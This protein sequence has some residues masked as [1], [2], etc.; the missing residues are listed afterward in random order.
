MPSKWPAS[1]E[2]VPHA[3]W[4][5]RISQIGGRDSQIADTATMLQC[6]LCPHR[7]RIREGQ[8]GRCGVR[9]N[10]KGSP[11]LPYWAR[12]SSLAL[13]PM[14]KKPLY[15]FRPGTGVL[16]VGF[17]GCNLACPFCQNWTISQSTDAATRL[18]EPVALVQEAER[19]GARS[20]A[21]TYSEPLIHF[22][23]LVQA[24]RLA[25]DKG[26]SNVLVTN[27]CILEGPARELLALTDAANVDL[28]SGKRETYT[29]VLGGDLE[30][31]ERFIALAYEAGVHLEATTLV[32]PN[33]NDSP[34]EIDHCA[35]FLAALSPDL[36]WHLSAYHP[37]FRWQSPPT[38]P[39]V[40]ELMA[41][42]ARKKLRYV[43]VGNVW[44]GTND[45]RCP[46]C[47]HSVIRR[48]GYRIDTSG[49]KKDPKTQ[50]HTCA[51]CGARLPIR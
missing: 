41:T 50:N 38:E 35:D 30:T 12:V 16:S 15:H 27:G 8:A 48:D 36:P 9:V 28:K 23:Y 1:P 33:L 7:C 2:G 49:L 26:I 6:A 45:T 4:L 21:Y 29:R 5:E 18:L 37:D 40:L 14:E 19:I 31:T 3:R 10:N 22:E 11:A 46:E 42:N 44:G 51:H 43:Y 32:V 20:L 25:R 34:A 24:M 39:E 17:V 47:G 13:D